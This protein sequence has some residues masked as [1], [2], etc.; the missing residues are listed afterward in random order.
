MELNDIIFKLSEIKTA[1]EF[2]NKRLDSYEHELN[3]LK[4]ERY[5]C[6]IDS[7]YVDTSIENMQK[8]LSVTNQ[9]I[10]Q[11]NSVLEATKISLIT[12]VGD[13]KGYLDRIVAL[14]SQLDKTVTKLNFYEKQIISL[15]NRTKLLQQD[16]L[17]VDDT[18]KHIDE[19]TTKNDSLLNKVNFTTKVIIGL[20]S[21]IAAAIGALI[22]GWEWLTKIFA[23]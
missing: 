14:E 6:H 20:I 19:V 2:C 10:Q 7:T 18:M 1:I 13:S 22:A 5:Q 4:E 11:L 8:E 16:I 9:K 12:H 23:R 17:N 3:S 21:G 15:I